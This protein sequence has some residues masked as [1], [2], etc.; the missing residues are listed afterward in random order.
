[1]KKKFIDLGSY[2][3]IVLPI[4][5]LTLVSIFILHSI[6][7]QIFPAYLYI[8]AFSF[9]VLFVVSKIDFEVFALFSTHLYIVSILLLV[10]TLVLGHL[11][12][13][14]VR[15]LGV[16]PASFQ[17]SEIVRPFLILFAAKYF[18]LQ[19]KSPKYIIKGLM[20][21]LIPVILVFMQP[22]LGMSIVLVCGFAGVILLS[23]LDKKF[24]IGLPLTA[25]IAIPVLW[26]I[27]APYQ[28]SRISSFL[29]SDFDKLGANYNS[30]QSIISV[31]S[32]GL[33]GRGLGKGVQT[34]LSFLPEKHTDF[35]F[36]SVSEE[37][38]FL[39]SSFTILLI[40]IILWRMLLLIQKSKTVVY[41]LFVTGAFMMLLS[42]T[43]IHVGMNMG[44]LPVTGIPMPFLSAGGSAYLANSIL[45]G[46]C[47][48]LKES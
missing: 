32:G 22:S 33:I 6:Y 36:A 4:V 1:M 12:R 21:M 15:W 9:L 2:L 19:I 16:G 45:I 10:I 35:M 5:F 13:G 38:G 8:I 31:G 34:Q 48:G 41:K 27:L 44:L 28:K 30:I 39:G 3:F 47:L 20:L 37:L 42:E 46:L 17:P 26:L 40:F 11:T 29:T 24:L 25:L 14:V 23:N 43:L 7:G 18:S